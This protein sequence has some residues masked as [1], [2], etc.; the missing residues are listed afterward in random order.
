MICIHKVIRIF[1]KYVDFQKFIE[2]K[3]LIYLLKK[4]KIVFMICIYN[5]VKYNNIN[6]LQQVVQKYSCC[7]ISKK[8]KKN[9]LMNKTFFFF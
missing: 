5:E 3:I 8:K 9:I 4:K 6:Y 2:N 1:L 7:L